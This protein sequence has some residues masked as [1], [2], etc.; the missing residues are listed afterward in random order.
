M[1]DTIHHPEVDEIVEA[2]K[3]L[4]SQ[5]E[6]RAAHWINTPDGEHAND[7]G[8]NDWCEECADDEIAKLQE[9]DPEGADGYDLDG[10]W[11]SEH[12]SP[13]HCAGCGARLTANL[14]VHGGVYELDHFK[15]H[16]P[17]PGN[18]GHAYEVSEMLDAFRNVEPEFE[19]AA[20][21]AIQIGRKLADATP[22]P[23][24]P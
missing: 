21:E 5:M 22:A 2:L 10:G 19:P 9:K 12:D 8:G 24:A 18:P 3:P 14:T 15:A 13:P 7:M 20:M 16:P 1:K 4:A 11:V 17:E 23:P 6:T